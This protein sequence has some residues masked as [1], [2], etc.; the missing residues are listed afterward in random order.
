[1]VHNHLQGQ[2]TIEIQAQSAMKWA[3]SICEHPAYIGEFAGSPTV[4]AEITLANCYMC[5]LTY[6]TISGASGQPGPD[7]I[8]PI[9]GASY[10]V[11]LTGT[12]QISIIGPRNW[13]Y[14]VGILYINDISTSGTNSAISTGQLANVLA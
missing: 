5:D 7:G 8:T 1:M 10:G 11:R 9:G 4:L 14:A 12:A 13:I 6:N 2:P 3:F